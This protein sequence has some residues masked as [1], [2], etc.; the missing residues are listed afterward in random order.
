MPRAK[1]TDVKPARGSRVAHVPSRSKVNGHEMPGVERREKILESAARLFAEHGYGDTGIDEIGEGAGVSGPAIYKHFSSKQDI[2]NELLLD[3]MTRIV[4][5]TRELTARRASPKGLLEDLLSARV[6][7]SVGAQRH[8]ARIFQ[9][10]E[11]NCSKE[12]RESLQTLR[13]A[14]EAEWLRVLVLLR[15]G[16]PVEGLRLAIFSAKVLIGYG[17]L[18]EFRGQTLSSNRIDDD[19]LRTQ[20]TNMARA[21]IMAPID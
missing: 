9:L 11:N 21:A 18:H 15:P 7:L 19:A 4:E 13:R 20:L 1:S 12:C 17:S 10:D 2:L 8:V 5:A 14:Y 3:H 6:E 16:V